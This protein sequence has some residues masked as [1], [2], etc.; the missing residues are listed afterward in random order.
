MK[1]EAGHDSGHSLPPLAFTW[2]QLVDHLAAER[3]GLTEL[4]RHL[5]DI[6]PSG[7]Q[8]SADPLTIERGLRRLRQQGNTPGNKY[9]RLLLRHYGVPR[10]I[11]S[12][13][14]ELG[15]YHSRSSDLPVSLRRD[16]L[17]LWDCPPIGESPKVAVW[18]QLALAS[19]SHREGDTAQLEQRLSLARL[20]IPHAEPAAL[21][22]LALFE[23]RLA[24]DRGDEEGCT[25]ALAR[26]EQLLA[27]L[28]AQ[29]RGCYLA[30]LQDQR[31]YRASRGWRDHPER[32]ILAMNH[33]EALPQEGE[34]FVLFRREHGRAWC[35]L[36]L[37]RLVEAREAAALACQHAG[38]G[39]FIRLRVMS[40]GLR[41]H[42][43]G[44]ETPEGQ[45]FLQRARQMA[46]RLGDTQLLARL[47]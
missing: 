1:T 44:P 22:E 25:D 36:R 12:W 31:A 26:A 28:Q 17:R 4:A 39:G 27:R 2:A 24:L 37:G 14:R 33:Y 6:A 23:A 20:L 40:L 8:L 3:G 45:T 32:L 16:Q 15:Q 13:A 41:A 18:I 46:E 35:L 38:D 19:V 21:S 34:P 9:G 29:E 10:S 30:R 5:L 47:G 43:E 42:L 7:A 11:A